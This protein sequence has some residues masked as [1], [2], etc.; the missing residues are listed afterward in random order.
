MKKLIVIIGILFCV[1][2][3]AQQLKWESY[4]KWVD[5]GKYQIPKNVDTSLT[6]GVFEVLR[7]NDTVVSNYLKKHPNIGK[8]K[9]NSQTERHHFSKSSQRVVYHTSDKKLWSSIQVLA[10][11]ENLVEKKP[12]HYVI[13][14]DIKYSKI[15][16]LYKKK[17]NSDQIRYV[18]DS[19]Y[20]K[21]IIIIND[22]IN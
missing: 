10:I 20:P 21:P 19:L 13:T 15:L 8:L 6:V 2:L 9:Y 14:D 4:N 5:I 3:S 7:I 12:P 17:Y 11:Y 16:E 1:V 18:M 22:T